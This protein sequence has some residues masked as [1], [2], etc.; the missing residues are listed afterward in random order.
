[1]S[2]LSRFN[3][4][5][6]SW[7]Q[8][9]TL[10]FTRSQL[11]QWIF[12]AILTV[13]A[14]A[15]RLKALGHESL[16]LDEIGHYTAATMPTFKAM[17]EDVR[18]HAGAAPLDYILLRG[19]YWLA[20]AATE[21]TIRIPYAFYGA[22]AVFVLYL[23]GK[24]VYG[25]GVGFAAAATL[26]TMPIHL[27]YSQEVRFYSLS[28]L[29]ALLSTWLFLRAINKSSWATWL[30]WGLGALAGLYTAYAMAFVLAAQAAYLLAAVIADR[31]RWRSH[32]L[33]AATIGLAVVLLFAP[34]IL[35]DGARDG[36][37][38]GDRFTTITDAWNQVIDSN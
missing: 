37:D 38:G 1:V 2:T 15:L 35:W 25:S 3:D 18:S 27:K 30:L 12:A 14:L 22:M 7:S 34:W 5:S 6:A 10:T 33:P 11:I 28:V 32:M 4:I 8:P 13:V 9:H 20:G 24:N 17:L 23:L 31:S 29:L 19:F 16:W 26:A 21:T 36:F